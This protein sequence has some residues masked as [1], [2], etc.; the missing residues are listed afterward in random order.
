[1]NLRPA[2]HCSNETAANV[3]FYTG[4]QLTAFDAANHRYSLV[5]IYSFGEEQCT[6]TRATV[7][8]RVDKYLKWIVSRIQEGECKKKKKKKV[9]YA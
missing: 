9:A 5:G 1:M 4:G 3:K 7:F 2:A 8:S 6:G